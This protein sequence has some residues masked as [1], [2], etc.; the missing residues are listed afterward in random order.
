MA[1]NPRLQAGYGFFLNDRGTWDVEEIP[2]EVLKDSKFSGD[3][4]ILGYKCNVF[5]AADGSTW[6]QKVATGM[7][8]RVA[9][10]IATH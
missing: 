5:D 4:S 1:T 6:A 8:E 2:P 10:K 3:L 7:I 9:W